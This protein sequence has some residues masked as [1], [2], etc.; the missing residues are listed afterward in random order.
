MAT[1]SSSRSRLLLLL[2]T[3][4]L[5]L[6]VGGAAAART[7]ADEPQ[8]EAAEAA[9]PEEDPADLGPALDDEGV[10]AALPGE[11]LLLMLW[12]NGEDHGVIEVRRDG[13]SFRTTRAVLRGTGLRLP[14][15]A[16]DPLIALEQLPGAE[17]R[18]D[19][20][21]QILEL[22]VPPELFGMAPRLLN[23]VEIEPAYA[24][25][26]PGAVLNYD[27]YGGVDE[28]STNVSGLLELRAFAGTDVFDT[29]AL[30]EWHE[31]GGQSHS[32]LLRLDSAWSRAWPEK[33]LRLIVGDT[34]TSATNWSRATRIG[35]IQLGTDFSL[36][37]YMPTVPI[38][39]FFGSAVLPSQLELYVNGVRTWTGGVTA[40][41]YELSTGPTR[42]DGAGQAQ[43]VLT[44]ALGR[45]TTQVYAIYDTPD[46][47]RAGL[48]EWSA[49]VGAV[50]LDYGIESFSYSDEPVFNGSYRRGITDEFTLEAHAEASPH[51]AQA[52]VGAV[53]LLGELGVVSGS[54]AA[55]HGNAGTGTQWSAGYNWSNGAVYVAADIQRASDDFADIATPWDGP[56]QRAR[57][58]VQAGVSNRWLGAVGVNYLRYVPAVGPSF[59]TAGVTWSRPL[60]KHVSLFAS[61]DQ[62][63]E[64]RH[65]R[66]FMISLNITPG[67]GHYANVGWQN[68][69][70]LD[71]VSATA[72]RTAPLSGGLGWHA[73]L[74][75]EIDTKREQ[76][77]AEISWLGP[78]GE[79]RVG[80][81]RFAGQEAAFAGYNG[82]LVLI[83]GG[84]YSSRRVDDGFALV[85][86][87]EF[88]D[89]P[90]TVENNVVGRTD[91]EGRLLVTRLNAYERN[92]V[93][94]D[95]GDLPADVVVDVMTARA[96]PGRRAGVIVE[97]PLRVLT[98]ATLTVTDAEGAPLPTGST[99]WLEGSSEPLVVGFDGQLYIENPPPGGTLTIES[100]GQACTVRLP[101]QI[102]PGGIARL[103]ALRC[104]TTP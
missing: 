32:S 101:A 19:A 99:A 98:A 29:T 17:L 86:T 83:G 3:E 5:L 76:G 68:Q 91:S 87:G 95:P 46:L 62:N 74:S 11:T 73:S 77:Q 8:A 93:G 53:V 79:A 100:E 27:I 52:G 38:P 14:G 13:E 45:V 44:D 78:N 18:Y 89:V 61:A 70:G 12:L 10:L 56:P 60:S 25:S 72:Q 2:L 9:P 34:V 85:S 71:T 55:S 20:D 7:P 28:S 33:R 26:A 65:D 6:A 39:A 51:V 37:P 48:S 21:L 104:E 43:V 84:L 102:E 88:A 58:Q 40:G 69:Q 41:P 35:G 22:V 67:R 92:L 59:R 16:A 94:I 80:V 42:I 75:R 24:D 82:A 36:Q 15:D 50:R 90:V 54:L 81:S 31:G 57:E 30:V 64:N 49:E 103:G 96:V 66:R 47:L 63:L 23:Q 4:A 1:A 97:F